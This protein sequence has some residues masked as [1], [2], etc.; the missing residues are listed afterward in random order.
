MYSRLTVG[1]MV[2][3]LFVS[4]RRIGF[5]AGQHRLSLEPMTD[6][7]L[8]KLRP[9]GARSTRTTARSQRDS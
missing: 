8:P 2:V 1:L 9:K 5:E 6:D 3:K 7:Y 4:R